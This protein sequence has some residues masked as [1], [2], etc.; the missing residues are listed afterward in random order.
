MKLTPT[1]W[2]FS[3]PDEAAVAA[4]MD[5]LIDT[6]VIQLNV[7]GGPAE[8]EVSDCIRNFLKQWQPGGLSFGSDFVKRIHELLDGVDPSIR[9]RVRKELANQGVIFSEP[10]EA[11]QSGQMDDC[12]PSENKC[13]A[14]PL[15]HSECWPEI[16]DGRD[17]SWELKYLP[18]K[19][20]FNHLQAAMAT[21]NWDFLFDAEH[22]GIHSAITR[23]LENKEDQKIWS[24][25]LALAFRNGDTDLIKGFGSL[26]TMNENLR[27]DAVF[28]ILQ[29]AHEAEPIIVTAVAKNNPELVVQ[30]A[31]LVASSRLCAADKG[32]LFDT[33]DRKGNSELS[34]LITNPYLELP[35]A[36]L[37]AYFE[38]IVY[39]APSALDFL[40][41]GDLRPLSEAEKEKPFTAP[42]LMAA[43]YGCQPFKKLEDYWSLLRNVMPRDKIREILT[44][45]GGGV[46]VAEKKDETPFVNFAQLCKLT[47]WQDVNEFLHDAVP[48]RSSEYLRSGVREMDDTSPS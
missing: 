45:L 48:K 18:E 24:R 40:A 7:S 21:G 13:L 9:N 16:W 8:S 17:R 1:S 6:I 26:V 44:E 46:F 29:A 19:V 11:R 36:G 5:R 25:Q 2:N 14:P 28:S 27:P 4:K 42:P 30:F 47:G 31:N 39:A 33:A 23:V 38:C 15:H 37:K 32:H 43:L 22:A 35:L 41:V 3:I 12:Q 10:D 34:C 20:A